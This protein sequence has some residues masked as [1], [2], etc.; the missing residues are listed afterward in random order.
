MRHVLHLMQPAR[1]GGRGGDEGGP[2]G[3]CAFPATDG[4]ANPR[5]PPSRSA[6]SLYVNSGLRPECANRGHSLTGLRAVKFDAKRTCDRPPSACRVLRRAY[7]RVLNSAC[8]SAIPGISGVGEKP[9]SA[10]GR[11]ACA[12]LGRPVDW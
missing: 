5:L 10:G 1:P 2:T 3:P 8:A 7:A 12:S 9:S 4:S 11:M 6:S